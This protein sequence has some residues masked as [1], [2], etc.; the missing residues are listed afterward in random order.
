MMEC[1]VCYELCPHTE[2]LLLEMVKA[3]ESA[4]AHQKELGFYRK[5]VLA[6]TTHP[7][8][9]RVCQDGGV[10]TSLLLY[11]IDNAI[12]DSAIV[13]KADIDIAIKPKAA[14]ALVPDDVFSSAGSK[15]F[16]SAAAATYGKAA[17]EYW[18]P[19]IAFVGTPC[20]VRAI[21]KLEAWRHRLADSVE[22]VIGLFC[23]WTFSFDLLLRYLLEKHGVGVYD[24]K[25]FAL[26]K[27]A[28]E[29]HTWRGIVN[30]PL[31]EVKAHV[32]DSCKLCSDFTAKF[33]DLSVGRAGP[34]QGLSIVIVR[35]E[36]G[37]K[38]LSTAQE[39]GF[40]KTMPIEEKAE[41]LP[42]V[43]EMAKMKEEGV[44]KELTL[45]KR[46]N[47]P[48]SPVAEKLLQV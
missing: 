21:R 6:R 30:I 46:K 41:V 5:I 27:E 44:I 23:L 34:L 20:Q 43:L 19:K 4:P 8:V 16:P 42:S 24:V 22:V 15:F 10:I 7:T 38:L 11:S 18:K 2:V 35:T 1:P 31:T 13:A 40:L 45:R 39:K 37:E 29:V 32:L 47:L 14:L 48:I 36:K 9:E 25:R 33:A 3:L 12:I 26:K 28:F 17:Y